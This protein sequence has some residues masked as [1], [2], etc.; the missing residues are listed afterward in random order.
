MKRR[1]KTD[2]IFIIDKDRIFLFIN[3]EL[4]GN[5]DE[6]KQEMVVFKQSWFN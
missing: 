4:V 3:K 5:Y 2:E 6:K 1:K